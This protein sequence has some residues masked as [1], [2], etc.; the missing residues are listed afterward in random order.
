MYVTVINFIFRLIIFIENMTI[1]FNRDVFGEPRPLVYLEKKEIP[2]T[3]LNQTSHATRNF[4][5]FTELR[6]NLITIHD[7]CSMPDG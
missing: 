5:N 6:S 1:L 4:Y 7:L 3:N 2:L